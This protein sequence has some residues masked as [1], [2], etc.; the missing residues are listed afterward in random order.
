MLFRSYLIFWDADIMAK[1]E[2]IQKMHN[3]LTLHP[4]VDYAYCSYKLGNKEMTGKKFSIDT[5]KQQ[6]YIPTTS[7]IR[8]EK[9]LLWDE[10]LKR[11][12]DWDLWL[13]MAKEGSIGIF[14]PEVLFIAAPESGISNW[15]PSFAY[16]SPWRYLPQFKKKVEAYER[17]KAI[18]QKKHNI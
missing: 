6:N 14:V 15:L 2:F 4:E 1:P 13:R 17:A 12:Q 8:T 18:I 9:A 5:L 10:S 16:K 11:F 3:V 7:L